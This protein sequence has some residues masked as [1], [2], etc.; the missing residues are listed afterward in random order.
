MSP[1]AWKPRFVGPVFLIPFTLLVTGCAGSGPATLLLRPETGHVAYAQTFS[2]AYCGK[3]QDGSYSCVLVAEERA[4]AA[5]PQADKAPMTPNNQAPLRQVV[6]IKILW[7]PMSGVRESVAAN[8][9]IDWYV[10]N[11]TADGGSD[12]LH[13]QGSGYVTLK[14]DDDTTKVKIHSAQMRPTAVHGTLSDPIGP[15]TL[16]GTFVALNND[17]RAADLAIAARERTATIASGQ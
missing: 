12:L 8:A 4:T 13:Y 16:T 14:G 17:Q 11:N 15:A 2:Q 6:Q 10:L 3:T 1:R 5:K 7:R 9:A